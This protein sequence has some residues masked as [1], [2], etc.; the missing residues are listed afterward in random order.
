MPAEEHQSQKLTLLPVTSPVYQTEFGRVHP[1]F[2]HIFGAN[3]SFVDAA[4][5]H[6]FWD[7]T[8]DGASNHVR[9]HL[10]RL[11]EMETPPDDLLTCTLLDLLE[12]RA[13]RWEQLARHLGW[14]M[15]EGFFLYRGLKKQHH[16]NPFPHL[17]DVWQAHMQEKRLP[18]P[19]YKMS[20]WTF[21]QSA[22]E[23]FVTTV[24]NPGSGVI[25][26]ADIPF[27]GT[28]ADVFVDDSYFLFPYFNQ[29][30]CVVIS[31][32]RQ[33]LIDPEETY[34]IFRGDHYYLEDMKA[35]KKALGNLA[36]P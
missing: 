2:Q 26:A 31:L 13:A 32:D 28:V 22:A 21:S 27:S 20:S 30:E 23:R 4:T 14:E 34:A 12:S 29:V 17:L 9:M 11:M 7:L 36:Y 25:L 19:A 16:F 1:S 5:E 15:P 24:E 6:I 18:F 35:L 33:V 3:M 10:V 8:D